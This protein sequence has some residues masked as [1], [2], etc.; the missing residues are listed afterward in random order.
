LLGLWNKCTL[1]TKHGS[2]AEVP[3]FSDKEPRAKKI[4]EEK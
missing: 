2:S 4:K 3:D 1:M